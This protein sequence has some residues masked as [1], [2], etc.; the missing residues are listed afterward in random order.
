MIGITRFARFVGLAALPAILPAFAK[1]AWL[2]ILPEFNPFK[3]NSFPINSARQS[4]LVTQALQQRILLHTRNHL[5]E[6]LP[7]I[8]TF[9]S[10]MDFTV[11]THAIVSALYVHLPTNG[12]ELVLFDVN[13]NTN[14]GVLLRSVSYISPTRLLSDPPRRF[15]TT[16][17]TNANPNTSDMVERVMEAG[18]TTEWYRPLGLSY[19]FDVFSLSHVALPFPIN[20]P[21]YGLQ[22]DSGKPF[23]INLGSIAARGERGALIVTLDSL[24][25]M[26]SN[27]F[28]PYLLER[29][30]ELITPES[31]AQAPHLSW[32]PPGTP[33]DQ[34]GE[35]SP[36][37]LS[38][39]ID[40]M[41][42]QP[43]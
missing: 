2:A 20:D 40:D 9:Q 6:Q 33:T 26:S 30:S 38:A 14:L 42:D 16:I 22:P 24:F 35:T 29:I 31:K 32:P 12:S 3:Y 28:F 7:P 18:K 23:G 10:A 8:V 37:A 27:P 39:G 11:S 41:A 25:R 13:R 4:Y 1:A 36:D 19:P 17:I 15:R 34:E 43:P 21:L 5:I